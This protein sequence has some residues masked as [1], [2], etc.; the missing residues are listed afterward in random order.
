MSGNGVFD[1][2]NSKRLPLKKILEVAEADEL[3]VFIQQYAKTDKR[4]ATLLKAKFA[5]N[6]TFSPEDDRYKIILDNIIPPKTGK[7]IPSQSDIKLWTS[8]AEDFTDQAQDAMALGRYAET[9]MILKA[10]IAKIDYLTTIYA[11]QHAEINKIYQKAISLLSQLL[12]IVLPRPLRDRIMNDLFDLMDKSYF[13]LKPQPINIP[14]ILISG[15]FPSAK[16]RMVDCIQKHLE[17]TPEEEKAHWLALWIMVQKDQAGITKNMPSSIGNPPF[18]QT[19]GFLYAYGLKKK[20]ITLLENLV[21]HHP[22]DKSIY[23]RLM[24]FYL[25]EGM[26]APYLNL[27]AAQLLHKGEFYWLDCMKKI[28]EAEIPPQFLSDLEKNLIDQYYKNR[29]LLFEFYNTFKR[30]DGFIQYLKMQDDIDWVNLP[31]Q[32]LYHAMPEEVG[33]LFLEKL[34]Y[35]LKLHFGEYAQNTLKTLITELHKKELPL[36]V[37]KTRK[38]LQ[39]NYPDRTKL[40]E[41]INSYI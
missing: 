33:A 11:L 34:D 25:A 29:K 9:W 38:W 21:H 6:L 28:P 15:F 26:T 1:A 20:A 8:I 24:D 16:K 23:H 12:E 39:S 41:I 37:A 5:R 40:L 32:K 35:F 7:H 27:C 3:K 13:H 18:F 10:V 30:W 2:E 36:L 17:I 4:L 14:Y 22:T 31:F 19:A